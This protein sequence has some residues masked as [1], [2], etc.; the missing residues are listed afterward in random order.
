M[1]FRQPWLL[2][3]TIYRSIVAELQ[4]DGHWKVTQIG[5]KDRKVLSDF[6]VSFIGTGRTPSI[7]CVR[8]GFRIWIADPSGNVIKTLLFKESM[9]RINQS[10]FEVPLLNPGQPHL[11]P[12]MNFGRCH[13]LDEHILIVSDSYCMFF[14]HLEHQKVVASVRCLRS[15][16]NVCV[17]NGEIFILEGP[18]NIIRISHSPETPSINASGQLALLNEPQEFH[19]ADDNLAEECFELPPIEAIDLDIPIKTSLDEHDLLQQDK[20]FL[21]HSRRVEVFEKI[22]EVGFDDSI[23]F[24]QSTSKKKFAGAKVKRVEP[25]GIVEIGH[26]AASPEEH[27]KKKETKSAESDKVIESRR[28]VD[29]VGSFRNDE[30]RYF[31]CVFYLYS[32]L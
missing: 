19:D 18:R 28:P 11:Q 12:P 29:V 15:I 16:R 6:G 17:R 14:L 2:V 24:K 5:K 22:N 32:Y 13:M 27:M 10:A 9:T 8:P 20:L 21:E 4:P 1:D 7:L 31:N 23:L 25:S 26:L 30:S 3:S